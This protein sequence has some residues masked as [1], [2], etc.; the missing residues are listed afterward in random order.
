MR[1]ASASPISSARP[2]RTSVTRPRTGRT[3]SRRSASE[4]TLVLVVGSKT[5]SNANRLVEVAR[6]CRRRRVSDRR[7][8]RPRPRLAR[9]P[10]GRGA[11]RRR[12][13]AGESSSS[14]SSTGLT[15]SAIDEREEVEI[16]RE[17]VFFRLPGRASVAL[18][19]DDEGERCLSRARRRA[20]RRR[21]RPPLPE[22]SRPRLRCRVS[23]RS[24]R[25]T[26]ARDV[27]FGV[28]PI[29]SSLSGP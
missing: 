21:L 2:R 6:D 17:D 4:A 1:S 8:A 5:S 16:A 3:R 28:L 9:G 25:P 11:H 22:R 20:Q 10:R 15:S 19:S 18:T 26:I 23:P 24:S 7:R 27:E 29:E 14:A 12:L 13:V